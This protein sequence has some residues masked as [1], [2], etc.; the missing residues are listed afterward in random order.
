M[1][2]DREH[3]AEPFV[4]APDVT[5]TATPFGGS[6]LVQGR[7]LSLIECGDKDSALLDRLLATG[8][9]AG[10]LAGAAEHMARDLVAGGWLTY[11]FLA[12]TE[13]QS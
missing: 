13:E 1:A 8:I 3:L 10:D 2:D 11:P 4:L 5:L 7:T 12:R 9:P 6:V